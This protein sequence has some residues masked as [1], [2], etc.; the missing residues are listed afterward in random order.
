MLQK[1]ADR[2][3]NVDLLNRAADLLEHQVRF[4]LKGE[5]RARVGL[6]LAVIRL[7]D[8]NAKGA[9]TALRESQTTDLPMGLE[10]DR[11]RIEAKA[12][13]ELGRNEDAVALLAG[14]ISRAAD[15]LRAD[16]YWLAEDWS[17]TAKVLPRLAGA[18]PA[19]ETTYGQA[20]AQIVLNWAV[21]LRL[22]N[23]ETEIERA[24][25]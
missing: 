7:L 22:N 19:A 1:L 20:Q 9:V 25:V 17:E 24:H 2:L 3:V 12:M 10:D 21:A 6:K 14:D 16:I 8:R 5:E 23:D 4:R 11:R 15:L 13:F 18:P